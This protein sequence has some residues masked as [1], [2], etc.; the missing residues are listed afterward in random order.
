[1]AGDHSGP[2]ARF[3]TLDADLGARSS[4]REMRS[5]LKL[6]FLVILLIF[7]PVTAEAK[8]KYFRKAEFSV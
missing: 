5:I 4:W 7:Q 3:A 2:K 1:V 8:T 6:Q